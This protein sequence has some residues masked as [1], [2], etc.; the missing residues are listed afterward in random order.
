MHGF[1]VRT[2]DELASLLQRIAEPSDKINQGPVV[3]R[4]QFKRHDYPEALKYKIT[5]NCPPSG[6]ALSEG[7]VG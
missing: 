5:E 7:N 2:H 3:V 4:V 1:A 6:G